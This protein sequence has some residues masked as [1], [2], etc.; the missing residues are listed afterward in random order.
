MNII[1]NAITTAGQ[2]ATASAITGALPPTMAAL[3]GIVV[4]D[5]SQTVTGSVTAVADHLISKFNNV[6]APLIQGVATQI[7][8]VASTGSQVVT[9]QTNPVNGATSIGTGSADALVNTIGAALNGLVTEKTSFFSDIFSAVAIPTVD[10]VANVAA[11]NSPALVL[12]AS[13]AALPVLASLSASISSVGT[14]T[15]G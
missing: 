6:Y 4:N 3:P 12:A 2:I 15:S 8:N 1:Q 14:V 7:N 9:G 11:S 5:A 13:A 10:A